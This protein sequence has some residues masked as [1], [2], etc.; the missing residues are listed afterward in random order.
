MERFISG[1]G[2]RD[3]FQ[4]LPFE[5]VAAM[6]AG[7]LV[8]IDPEGEGLVR[9]TEAVNPCLYCNGERNPNECGRGKVTCA[10]FS[11]GSFGG[12][13]GQRLWQSKSCLRRDSKTTQTQELDA[14]IFFF[15]EVL[16][17]EIAHGLTPATEATGPG[18]DQQVD[19]YARPLPDDEPKDFILRL[20][21]KGVHDDE[22]QYRLYEFRI[23]R[24]NLRQWQAHCLVSEISYPPKGLK[25]DPD[26]DKYGKAYR[27][28]KDRHLARVGAS[29]KSEFIPEKSEFIT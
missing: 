17:Y 4:W 20:K 29:E 13:G 24:W 16:D 18:Q 8:P 28:A 26:R 15:S 22:I 11:L 19:G 12:G 9:L 1:A 27:D 25:C 10:A 3:R 2:V 23:P 5:L 6:K 7:E 14:A 21:G